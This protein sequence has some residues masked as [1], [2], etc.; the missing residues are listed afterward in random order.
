MSHTRGSDAR[1][2]PMPDL[3]NSFPGPFATSPYANAIEEQTTHWLQTFPLTGSP[4]EAK[5][6]CNITAQGV[7][8]VLP[9]ADQDSVFLCADLFLWLTAFDDTHGETEGSRDTTRL[10]RRISHCVHLLAGH[11]EPAADDDACV[12]ALRELLHRFRERATPTQYL[13]LTAHLRDN[14]FGILWEAHHL[15]RLDQVTLSDYYAMRPHTVFVRTVMT[16]TEVGLGYELTDNQR[17]SPAVRELEKAVADLAGWINDLASY[18]KETDRGGQTPLSLPTLLI[19]HHE[20]NLEEAFHLASRMCEHQA[21][22]ARLRI[23]ELTADSTNALANHARAMEAVA[24]SY[25]WH[26]GH[27][28]YKH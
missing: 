3:Q 28:R 9:T 18:A 16:S 20:C 24:A 15:D 10:V 21:S 27:A 11:D 12:A 2:L 26:I 14:L 25:V 22:T 6:L 13:R 8:R 5:A 7:A 4:G 19:R 1:T 23:T 17:A